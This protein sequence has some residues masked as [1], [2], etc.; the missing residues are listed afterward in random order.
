MK[1]IIVVII[2]ITILL[3]LCVGCASNSA[4]SDGATVYLKWSDGEEELHPT[5]IQYYNNVISFTLD[6]GTRIRTSYVNVI[7]IE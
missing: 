7:I 2:T 6:D 1:K 3:S 4:D 5:S